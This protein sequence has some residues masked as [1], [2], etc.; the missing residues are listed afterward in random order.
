MDDSDEEYLS[1]SMPPSRGS[2]DSPKGDG[3]SR[4]TRSSANGAISD[5]KGANGY[6]WEDEIQRSWDI[7]KNDENGDRS[8]ESII[9]SMIEAR[10]KKIMR[11]PSTPFQR[12]II[13]TLIVV[14]DGSLAMLEKDL[15]PTRFAMTLSLIQEFIV[16]FFDQNP[17]SQMGILMMR[18][19]V[20]NVISEVSGLPQY[21]IDKIRQL[22]ARQHNRYEPKGDPSL[23][24]S[25]EMARS[26]L[27][28][29][30]GGGHS[31]DTKNSKEILLIFGALFTSDPGDIHKTI[32]HLVRDDIKV[33]IIGLS[34]QVSICQELVNRT[35]N[36]QK[37]ISSK[38]YG[39]I[40]HETHFRELLMDCVV[41][42]PISEKDKAEQNEKKNGVPLIK[43]GFPS[44]IQPK[45]TVSINNP[46]FNI[47]FPQLSASHPT[48]GS[49]DSKQVVEVST[50][51]LGSDMNPN[52]VIGYQ[53][54]Q[55][56]NKVS[57]LPTVCP[58]CGLMLI[59]STHLARS[60]H[61]LVP[62]APFTEV[63]VSSSY[64]SQYCYGCLLMFPKGVSV[65]SKASLE[66]MTS[67]RYRCMKCSNDFCIDCDVFVHEALHNCPGCENN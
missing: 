63:P 36:E 23:Q 34:A 25:L 42:L 61:H 48:Q 49:E 11:N 27:M 67:S 3:V 18:N 26:M 38:N 46:N 5:L 32:D 29:N 14:I 31:N 58:V 16:E 21:H 33:K 35:N 52:N 15:R 22:K 7:V 65:K 59:L 60:Y 51:E 57:N 30:F 24:N 10:K 44:K 4:R 1:P 62:L 55:C 64:T 19:G 56:K 6:A 50:G 66:S 17:I 2:T 28:Y 53:C 20:S 43:M 39:V 54:P 9:Q 12:G 40:M 41:P 8:L 37:S 45:F 47:D 13:R